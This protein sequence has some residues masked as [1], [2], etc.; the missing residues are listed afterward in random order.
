MHLTFTSTTSGSWDFRWADPSSG[1]WI[2]TLQGLIT[3][4][5]ITF[6]LPSGFTYALVD[7]GGFT[8]IEEVAVAVVPEPSTLILSG[9]GIV[10]M[11]TAAWW[12][13]RRRG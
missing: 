6:T 3:G 10:G 11:A 7:T 8:Y 2:S 13:R 12:R 5:E 4:G 1:N 9:L